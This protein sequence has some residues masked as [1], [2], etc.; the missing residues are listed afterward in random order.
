[1]IEARKANLT[2]TGGKRLRRRC[3]SRSAGLRRNCP[4]LWQ[5]ELTSGATTAFRRSERRLG[6]DKLRVQVQIGARTT[7]PNIRGWGST[8]VII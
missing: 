7:L 4:R 8:P 2:F 6:Q 3:A 5:T 1:M